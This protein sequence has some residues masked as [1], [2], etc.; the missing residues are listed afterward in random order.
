[1]GLRLPDSAK[2]MAPSSWVLIEKSQ[3]FKQIIYTYIDSLDHC[4]GSFLACMVIN[5]IDLHLYLFYH[6]ES[7]RHIT[8]MSSLKTYQPTLHFTTW[9]SLVCHLYSTESIQACSH[10]G[11][12]NLSHT[13]PSLYFQVLIYTWVKWHMWEWSAILTLAVYRHKHWLPTD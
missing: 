8:L 10:F 5:M 13:F 1:M 9:S 2:L 7:I 6:V 12:L 11:A 3:T 4:H